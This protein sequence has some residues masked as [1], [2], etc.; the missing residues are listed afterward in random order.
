MKNKKLL[1]SVMVIAMLLPMAACGTPKKTETP[2]IDGYNLLWSDE[3]DGK[4][5]EPRNGTARHMNRVGQT[6]SCRNT[7]ILMRTFSCATA[8]SY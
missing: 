6:T 3:F 5:L 8:I 1:S 4:E 2:V 7:R